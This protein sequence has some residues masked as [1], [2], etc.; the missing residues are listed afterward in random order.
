MIKFQMENKVNSIVF[1]QSIIDS[2]S[3]GAELVP[4]LLRL[5]ILSRIRFFKS[6]FILTRYLSVSSIAQGT[7][8]V[9]LSIVF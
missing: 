5:N 9:I 8:S 4:F 6:S 1:V 2:S 7:K 3:P